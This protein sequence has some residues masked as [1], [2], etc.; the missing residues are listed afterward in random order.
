MFVKLFTLFY[1]I[2]LVKLHSFKQVRYLEVSECYV[3]FSI[4]VSWEA[5]RLYEKET[6]SKREEVSPN[7]SSWI[8]LSN[9]VSGVQRQ[10]GGQHRYYG[11][12]YSFHGFAWK[13]LKQ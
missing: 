9:V 11:I 2:S 1:H 12:T 10:D 3:T 5:L 4:D 7:E 13:V 6:K 8:G